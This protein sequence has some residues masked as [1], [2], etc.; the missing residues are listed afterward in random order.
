MALN[1][2]DLLCKLPSPEQAYETSTEVPSR[3]TSPLSPFRFRPH[4]AVQ[5]ENDDAME[6]PLSPAACL[7]EASEGLGSV[8]HF[9]LEAGA[10]GWKQ[11][12]AACQE[13]DMKLVAWR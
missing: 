3:Y 6:V 2:R 5:E 1:R 12:L 9:M 8:H 11:R 13:L 7:V 10:W 4:P